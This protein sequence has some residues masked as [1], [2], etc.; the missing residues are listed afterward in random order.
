MR[1]DRMIEECQDGG[2]GASEEPKP[3]DFGLRKIELIPL[4]IGRKGKG[5]IDTS[6]VTLV[7]T[8]TTTVVID[9]GSKDAEMELKEALVKNN[10]TKFFFKLII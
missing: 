7:K 3:K 4:V 5:D 1:F 6:S 2:M 9:T 8:P 10:F